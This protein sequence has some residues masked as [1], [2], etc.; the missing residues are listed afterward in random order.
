MSTNATSGFTSGILWTASSPVAWALTHCMPG[1]SLNIFASVPRSA[2]LSSTMEALI[3]AALSVTVWPAI[4]QRDF[5]SET[6]CA[7]NFKLTID[8]LH[9][10]TH[11]AETVGRTIVGHAVEPA[12]VVV[13]DNDKVLFRRGNLKANLTGPGMPDDVVQC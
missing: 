6:G 7:F 11:V 5:G 9:A 4:G 1:A 12:T 8:F 2:A 13:N 3:G 10:L